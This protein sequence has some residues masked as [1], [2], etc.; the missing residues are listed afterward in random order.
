[1]ILQTNKTCVLCI[2]IKA[3]FSKKQ[4][5]LNIF[6]LSW[7]AQYDV[8]ATEDCQFSLPVRS[9]TQTQH[10][11]FSKSHTIMYQNIAFS[12]YSLDILLAIVSFILFCVSFL[13]LSGYSKCFFDTETKFVKAKKKRKMKMENLTCRN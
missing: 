1:M 11:Y 7:P 4:V 2:G 13:N 6:Y 10:L 12:R 5:N 3:V 9:D 8:I